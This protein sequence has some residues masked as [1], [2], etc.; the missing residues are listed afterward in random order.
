MVWWKKALFLIVAFVAWISGLIMVGSWGYPAQYFWFSASILAIG[1]AVAPFWRRRGSIW[2][3]PSVALI[4][5][6]NLAAMYVERDYVAQRD[7]PSKGVV[8]G[9]LVLD[10][11]S[12]WLLMVGVA[13]LADRRFPWSD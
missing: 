8:Q 12:S 5:V 11:I 6:I 2:Y 9:L 4:I 13:Y 10:C 3:W 1:C 7:L